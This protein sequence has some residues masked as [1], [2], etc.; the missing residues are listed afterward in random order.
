ML[1]RDQIDRFHRDG[2]LVAPGAVTPAQLAA[3]NRTLAG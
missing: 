1:D 2:F 3:L